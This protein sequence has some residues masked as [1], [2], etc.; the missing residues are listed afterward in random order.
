MQ[1]GPWSVLCRPSLVLTVP[2]TVFVAELVV[3][4]PVA[5]SELLLAVDS[6]VV[7]C[8]AVEGPRAHSCPSS[9]FA[10][11]VEG[12]TAR[13][14]GQPLRLACHTG[15]IAVVVRLEVPGHSA[16]IPPVW[17]SPLVPRPCRS[18]RHC[19]EPLLKGTAQKPG[20]GQ[21]GY[22]RRDYAGCMPWTAAPPTFGRNS[23]RP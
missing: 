2:P 4:G 9:R 10:G 7:A 12:D 3:P 23:G 14:E 8:I 1:W 17:N 15:R 5:D 19:S 6:L 18:S 21:A 16:E 22:T 11:A 20:E 13:W